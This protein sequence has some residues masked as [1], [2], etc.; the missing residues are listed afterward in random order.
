M[1]RIPE[2]PVIASQDPQIRATLTPILGE[3]ARE[4]NRALPTDQG[5]AYAWFMS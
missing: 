2:Q 5:L 3:H 1:T 4:I